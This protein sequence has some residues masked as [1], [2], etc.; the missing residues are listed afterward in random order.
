MPLWLGVSVWVYLIVSLKLNWQSSNDQPVE[1]VATLAECQ[2]QSPEELVL[3]IVRRKGRARR[4]DF[5]AEL[6]MPLTSLGRLLDELESQGKIKQVGEKKAA[7]Y[8]LGYK[9]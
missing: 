1:S 5:L 3:N 8:E 6:N 9:V 7:F 4:E 2:V